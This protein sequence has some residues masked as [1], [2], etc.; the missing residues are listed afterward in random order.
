[1][2]IRIK[3]TESQGGKTATS[4][5]ENLRAAFKVKDPEALQGKSVLLIDDVYTTGAT[6]K[7]CTRA[8]K[9]AGAKEVHVLTATRVV[10]GQDLSF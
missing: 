9:R 8:L 3:A 1:M 10:R 5:Y 6:L 4:R 2:D 7:G